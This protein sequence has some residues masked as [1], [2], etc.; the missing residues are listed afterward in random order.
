MVQSPSSHVISSNLNFNTNY[1]TNKSNTGGIKPSSSNNG[2]S[3]AARVASLR[4]VDKKFAQVIVD[5]IYDSPCN[6]SFES[7]AGQ[8]TAKQALNEMVILPTQRSDIFTG[9]RAPPKGL[10]LFG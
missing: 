4:G 1:K 9:L 3:V 10:L 7:V 5:E 2:L 6:I 8:E